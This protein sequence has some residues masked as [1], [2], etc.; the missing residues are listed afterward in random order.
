[1]DRIEI[2]DLQ[3]ECIIGVNP[4]ERKVKQTVIVSITLYTDLHS[5]G[6]S[7]SIADTVDYTG[8]KRAVLQHIENS[9]HV[10]IEKLAHET[11]RICVQDSRV[12]AVRVR[13]EKPGAL[14]AVRAV[15]VDIERTADDYAQ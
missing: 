2:V 15:A 8:V 13:V 1:M 11:G 4:I 10:L 7:D 9:K 12:T 3:A 14:S 5:A 6:T